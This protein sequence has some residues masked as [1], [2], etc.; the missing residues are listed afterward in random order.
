VLWQLPGNFERDDGRLEVALRCLPPGRHAFEFRHPS[1][2]ASDVYALLREQGASLVVGDHPQRPYQS[3]EA[4]TDWRYV[5]FHHG[6]RGR[7]GNYSQR[8]LETWVRRLRRW[9]ASAELY[10]YFNNDWEAF[11]LRNARWLRDRL[12]ESSGASLGR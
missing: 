3:H 1:W 8:E 6:S 12:A 11:A 2:F 4:T 5:R 9:R 10:L 7:R